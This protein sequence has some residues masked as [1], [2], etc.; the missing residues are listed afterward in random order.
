MAL[1]S[2]RLPGKP[3]LSRDLL[4]AIEDTLGPEATTTS[5]DRVVQKVNSN[6]Q[7]CY[8]AE[9][10]EESFFG[11]FDQNSRFMIL[12][13]KQARACILAI[14]VADLLGLLLPEYDFPFKRDR[15]EIWPILR[16]FAKQQVERNQDVNWYL[17]EE[18]DVLEKESCPLPP[19]AHKQA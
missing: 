9:N 13:S 15:D 8:A 12:R 3:W 19:L 11:L 10:V 4:E 5:W 17:Y 14:Y 2:P 7:L 6:P 1:C 16:D 18:G